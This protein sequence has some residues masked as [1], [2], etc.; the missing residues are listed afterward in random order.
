MRVAVNDGDRVAKD[1]ILL[2]VSARRAVVGGSDVD[3]AILE[4]LEQEQQRLTRRIS[5]TRKLAQ[6]NTDK[7]EHKIAGLKREIG[8]LVRQRATQSEQVDTLNSQLARYEKLRNKGY[9][10]VVKYQ[11]HYEDPALRGVQAFHRRGAGRQP[12]RGL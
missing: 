2:V 7:L 5:L 12:G 3:T 6:R 8:N 10:S 4:E 9:L 11:Q 1:Q